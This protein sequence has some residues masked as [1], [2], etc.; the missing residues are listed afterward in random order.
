[1]FIQLNPQPKSDS[2]KQQRSSYFEQQNLP[3]GFQGDWC[4]ALN[5][6]SISLVASDTSSKTKCGSRRRDDT[7]KWFLNSPDRQSW[8][9]SVS[10]RFSVR[11][12]RWGMKV[13]LIYAISYIN[14]GTFCGRA[15]WLGKCLFFKIQPN[16]EQV[17]ALFVWHWWLLNGRT[18]VWLI[19][20]CCWL[21]CPTFLGFR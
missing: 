1:M 19:E 20:A 7:M 2:T 3:F 12:R 21:N 15:Y 17:V 9:I 10:K 11:R 6:R 16:V 13:Q 18:A 5:E 8:L 4:V 14:G